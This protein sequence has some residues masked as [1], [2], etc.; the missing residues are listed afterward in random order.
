MNL[1]IF[2]TV[3]L[4]ILLVT[5]LT[6]VHPEYNALETDRDMIEGGSSPSPRHCDRASPRD[7]QMTTI[8]PPVTLVYSAQMF[9]WLYMGSYVL[10]KSHY[11]SPVYAGADWKSSDE[12]DPDMINTHLIRDE[13]YWHS[14]SYLKIEP[15]TVPENAFILDAT[16]TLRSTQP[17]PFEVPLFAKKVEEYWD[18]VRFG[19]PPREKGSF[20]NFPEFDQNFNGSES[21]YHPDAGSDY[22]FDIEDAVNAWIGG[23]ENFGICLTTLKGLPE[24]T[25]DMRIKSHYGTTYFYGL[26]SAHPPTVS[27]DYMV[28]ARPSAMITSSS[29][30]PTRAGSP[31]TFSGLGND[32]DG[33]GIGMYEWSSDI[34][35]LLA[36]GPDAQQVVIDNLS[37]GRHKVKLRVQDDVALCPRWSNPVSQYIDITVNNP[38][39]TGVVSRRAGSTAPAFEFEPGDMIDILVESEG[40]HEPLK[41]WVNISR[42]I[43]DTDVISKAPLDKDLSYRWDTMGQPPDIYEVHAVLEDSKGLMDHDGLFGQEPDLILVL[44]DDSPPVVEEVQLSSSGDIAGTFSLGDMVDITVQAGGLETGLDAEVYIKNPDGVPT[45]TAWA[46]EPSTDPGYYTTRWD[47]SMLEQGGVYTIKVTLTDLSG[48]QCTAMRDIT[49]ID[50][51]APSVA[52]VEAFSGSQKDYSFPVATVVTV[53]VAEESREEGLSGYLE[54]KLND[55]YIEYQAPLEMMSEGVY[56]FPW[57]TAGMD[58]G[59]YAV[60]VTLMDEDG[61]LDPNG[62]GQVDRDGNRLPDLWVRLTLPPAGLAVIETVPIAGE[63]DVPP[64]TIL[65]INFSKP[66]TPDSVSMHTLTVT[67]D[68]GNAVHGT[69]TVVGSGS[70]CCFDPDGLLKGRTLYTVEVS[71]DITTTDGRRAAPHMMSFETADARGSGETE[72][73]FTPEDLEV[74]VPVGKNLS[75]AVN[76]RSSDD[77]TVRWSLNNRRVDNPQG[78][79]FNLNTTSGMVGENTVEALVLLAESERTVSWKVTVYHPSGEAGNG[80]PSN[81]EESGI[82]GGEPGSDGGS[83]WPLAGALLLLTVAV[84]VNVY[85]LVSSKGKKQGGASGEDAGGGGEKVRAVKSRPVNGPQAPRGVRKE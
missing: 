15:F 34:D 59:W 27:I 10:N 75:F 78:S 46:L 74:L 80:V 21:L 60:N 1:R 32:P 83:V 6:P 82:A 23:E 58:P 38:E 43:D 50:T 84:V 64:E 9:P 19:D 25:G 77:P 41:G 49:L 81:T 76:V 11:D 4:T 56:Y 7:H 73:V 28:N 39:V 40:G 14:R 33:D 24:Q 35:G 5:C 2:F 66:V 47:T 62:L 26:G 18:K 71:E 45:G 54:I 53:R 20:S 61:N 30:P 68:Q 70:L 3:V 69:W 57:K 55:N 79:I 22:D 37:V 16:L 63:R 36:C 72:V 8:N 29:H 52:T 65:F 51:I 12:S 48:N 42:W 85:I 13:D 67:D 31:V 44:T 17:T